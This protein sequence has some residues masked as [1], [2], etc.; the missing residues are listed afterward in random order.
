MCAIN[1]DFLIE[2]AQPIKIH[3]DFNC[4]LNASIKYKNKRVKVQFLNFMLTC[5][6]EKIVNK[7]NKVKI[8]N[9]LNKMN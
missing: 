7:K 6:R 5:T 9:K 2:S 1:V 3:I 4:H 8:R